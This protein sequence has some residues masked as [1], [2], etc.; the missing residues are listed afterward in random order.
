[1]IILLNREHAQSV[2]EYALLIAVFT[3]VLIASIPNLRS[4][5][6]SVFDSTETALTENSDPNNTV[7]PPI[8]SPYLWSDDLNS[9]EYWT[10]V[11]GDWEA[12]NGVLRNTSSGEGRIFT[13]YSGDNFMVD[14]DS[15]HL[16]QDDGYGVWLR[17]NEIEGNNI[18]GYTFQYD[19]GYSGGEFIMRKWVNGS[20]SFPFARVSAAG[21]DWY[22]PHKIQVIANGDNF[23]VIIDGKQVLSAQ[24]STYSSGQVGL[25]TWSATRIELQGFSIKAVPLEPEP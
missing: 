24:D 16:L 18:N 6:L 14:I 23:T 5:V 20:E 15:T 25:R 10:P 21:Y 2:L 19:P 17:A 12:S 3:L 13:P 8:P 7:D 9:L 4:S 22:N 11:E 1:M